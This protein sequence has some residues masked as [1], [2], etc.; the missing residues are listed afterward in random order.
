MAQQIMYFTL[1]LAQIPS[2]QTSIL[3]FTKT[4]IM[5]IDF[6]FTFRMMEAT[7]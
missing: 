1:I 4:L 3:A 5:D 6:S 7:P 2:E